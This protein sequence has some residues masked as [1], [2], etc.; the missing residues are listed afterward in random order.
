MAL[1]Y[2]NRLPSQF[3]SMPIGVFNG[4]TLGASR[5]AAQ[6]RY[7]AYAQLKMLLTRLGWHSTMVVTGD[8]EQT[9]LL[10]GLSGLAER[11]EKLE[12]LENIKVVR[13]TRRDVVRHPLVAE[14]VAAL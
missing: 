4:E 9:D 3:F 13:F 12:S 8:P 11:A 6:I 10:A 2:Q 14:M 5:N 1:K 7:G